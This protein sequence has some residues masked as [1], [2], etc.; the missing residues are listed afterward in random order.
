MGMYTELNI[1]VEL[2]LDENT[3]KILEFMV[4][5]EGDIDFTIPDHPLFHLKTGRWRMMLGCDSFYFPH[6][7]DSSLINR[8][9]WRDPDSSERIL[10][11][12]CDLKDY[13]GEI[14]MFLDWIYP[15]A[16]TRGFIGYTRYEECDNPT[17]IYF[18]DSGVVCKTV[19]FQVD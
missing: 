15:Y 5:D 1:A 16:K 17:L 3:R 4:N 13:E 11:V 6:T 14:D 8:V 10:N 2:N 19:D 7:A 12:R 18:T 9:V